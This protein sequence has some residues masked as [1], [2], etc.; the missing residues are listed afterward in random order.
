MNDGRQEVA[1]EVQASAAFVLPLPAQK[2]A[3]H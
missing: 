2:T 1:G 3:A